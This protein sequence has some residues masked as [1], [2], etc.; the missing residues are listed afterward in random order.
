[1]MF[2]WPQD[3]PEP[4]YAFCPALFKCDA[5]LREVVCD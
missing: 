2:H 5:A 1:M 4:R 3:E